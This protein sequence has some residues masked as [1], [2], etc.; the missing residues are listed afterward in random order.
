MSGTSHT[1]DLFPG[2]LFEIMKHINVGVEDLEL[3]EFRY[4]LENITPGLVGIQSNWKNRRKL[5]V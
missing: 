1:P 4:A 2:F 3:Y 5:N